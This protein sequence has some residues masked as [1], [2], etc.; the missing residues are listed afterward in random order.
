MA[1]I[2]FNNFRSG[3]L[4]ADFD[5]A[6]AS[7]KAM[8]V[9]SYTLDLTDVTVADMV[10]G[11]GVINGTSAALGTPTVT[12]GVF[13]AADTTITTTASGTNHILVIA[14][15]SAVTGGADLPTSGQLLI[16]Y[17]DTGTGLPIQPGTGVVAVTWSAGA[18]KILAVA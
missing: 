8:L 7:I 3:I 14:Q 12:N 4:L 6:V 17:I 11:G 5:L 1:N 18:A 15:T 10:A 16:A 2:A 9:R 13:D